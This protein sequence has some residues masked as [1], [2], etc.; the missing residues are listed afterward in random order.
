MVMSDVQTVRGPIPPDQLGVTQTHEHLWCNQA[1]CRQTDRWRPANPRALMILDELDLA[2]EE[3]TEVK[4]LGGGAIVEATVGGWGRDVAKLR[5]LSEATGLHIVACGGYYVEACHPAWAS[6][7]DVDA[8][9]DVL[10]REATEGADGTDITV[11]ILK[12][13]ISRPVIE[14]EEERCA[15]AVARAQRRTGLAITTHTSGN[16]RFEIEGGNIGMQHLDLFESEGVDPTRVIVG[17]TD[18]NADV[19]FLEALCRRGAFVQFDVIGKRHWM[20]DETRA[21][22]AVRLVER[23]FGPHLLLGSDRARKT[24]LLRYG[25]VGYR[26]LLLTFVPMLRAAGLEEGAIRMLLVENPARALARA[27]PAH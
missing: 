11:G 4:A 24:E 8:L 22:L 1:L 7:L 17:H 10:V 21:A 2:V 27:E 23:G 3:L 14:G 5:E 18:E 20:L 9:A 19:R 16:I 26:H 13:A 6:S 12:S 25:G 15:R